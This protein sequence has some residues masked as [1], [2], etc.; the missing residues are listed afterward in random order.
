MG[1]SLCG[2][3]S[4]LDCG[5]LDVLV[6]AYAQAEDREDQRS[7]RDCDIVPDPPEGQ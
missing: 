7:T 5:W 3:R 6:D 1:S 2:R 4:R